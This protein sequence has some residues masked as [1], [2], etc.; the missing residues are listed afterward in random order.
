MLQKREEVLAQILRLA[1]EWV[2]A[3]AR[4]A[5]YDESLTEDQRACIFTFGSYRLTVHNPG[6]DID[7]LLVAPQ[8]C[9]KDGHF[10]GDREGTFQRMLADLGV[11]NMRP[12]PTA[13]VPVIKCEL[14]GVDMDILFASLPLNH[15]PATLD[16]KDDS[17]L[18]GLDERGAATLNGSRVTDTVLEL[19]PES[20][21]ES[22]RLALKFVKRWGERRGIY[23][24]NLGLLGGINFAML[25][26]KTCQWYPNAAASTILKHFFTMYSDWPWPKPVQLCPTRYNHT[27]GMK[28]W[29]EPTGPNAPKRDVLPI[30]TPCYPSFNSTVNASLATREVLIAELQRGKQVC[31]E[32]LR[33]ECPD[34]ARLAEEFD[35]FGAYKN[36]LQVEVSAPDAES[37]GRWKGAVQARL[38]HLIG[39]LQDHVKVRPWHKAVSPPA[40]EGG[41]VGDGDAGGTR[42]AY[43]FLAVTKRKAKLLEWGPEPPKRVNFEG[44]VEQ[45]KAKRLFTLPDYV[46]GV[47][48]GVEVNVSVVSRAGLP[49][50]L[51]KGK[52]GG[53]EE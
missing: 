34:W 18:R 38:R 51:G 52:K 22:F 24:N 35:F 40:E 2:Q 28:V 53:E 49:S 30:L 39:E 21:R 26:A 13:F 47:L 6:G 29:E 15:L 25:V 41:A 44:I 45:W 3:C 9:T 27:L 50:W 36:F 48:Q 1:N 5:G 14:W 17:V 46:S 7:V 33:Q 31:D 11:E 42:V 4:E 19:V 20:S 32:I 37:F 12:V 16:L 43:F 8:H 23:S 10:F